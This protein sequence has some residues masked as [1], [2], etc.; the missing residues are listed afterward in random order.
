MWRQR[1][2]AEHAELGWRGQE[3]ERPREEEDLATP[4]KSG[5]SL[6][7][8]K[9]TWLGLI[10]DSILGWLEIQ[11]QH[12]NAPPEMAASLTPQ[13]ERE[14]T[15]SGEQTR[16]NAW[17]RHRVLLTEG[18]HPG[19]EVLTQLKDHPSDQKALA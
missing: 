13:N 2:C 6:G 15:F 5:A 9:G 7:A 10:T 18:G 3:P 19:T 11:L 14:I 12:S 4:V 16:L 17:N 8:R 1:A